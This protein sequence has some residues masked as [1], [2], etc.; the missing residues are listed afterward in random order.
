MTKDSGD[1]SSYFLAIEKKYGQPIQFWLDALAELGAAKYPQQI[2]LLREDHGFS[3]THAN[4]VVMFIRGSTTSKRF[5]DPEAYLATL[6]EPHQA[7]TKAIL[8]ATLKLNT[9]FK[10][11]MAWNKPIVRLGKECIIGFSAAK[12]HLLLLPFGDDILQHVD[13][14]LLA[15]YKVNKKTIQVPTDWKIDRPLLKQLVSFRVA[16]M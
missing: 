2:A 13:S 3:Q 14:N 16:Q 8:S 4:A 10:V 6:P 1:R 15:P 9:K 12:N 5:T 11:V 7:T